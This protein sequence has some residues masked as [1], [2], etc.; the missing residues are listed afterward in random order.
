MSSQ[1]NIVLENCVWED[2]AGEPMRSQ[3][4]GL[5]IAQG[6]EYGDVRNGKP[7]SEYI[8]VKKTSGEL[9]LTRP[10]FL[11]VRKRAETKHFRGR[12]LENLFG[13]DQCTHPHGRPELG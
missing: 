13:S 6:R 8:A 9:L 12:K 2:Q 3:A 5:L 10:L 4:Q 11:H 1:H 7:L